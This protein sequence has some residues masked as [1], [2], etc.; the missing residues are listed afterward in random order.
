M[1]TSFTV[2]T[3]TADGEV[4]QCTAVAAHGMALE[5]VEGK[6]EVIVGH[7]SSHNVLL[8][9]GLILYGDANL[10]VLVHDIHRRCYTPQ[11]C[12][13]PRR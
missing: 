4:F 1:F 10:V 2:L 11:Q 13:P 8:D 7:V 9:L 5:V 3:G 12:R 6:H